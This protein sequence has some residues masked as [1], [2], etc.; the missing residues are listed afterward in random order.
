MFSLKGKVAVITGGASGIGKATA[1]R[2][3]KAG[4]KVV[5]ADIQDAGDVAKEAGGIYVRTDVTKEGEVKALME[6][7]VSECGKLDI[8]C[9]N[10]GVDFGAPIEE[11]KEEDFDRIMN[12]NAKS[13]LWGVKHA[14]PRMSDGG[15][16]INTS[17]L[18]GLIGFPEYTAYCSSKFAIVGISKTAALELA[19][20]RIRVNC[21]CPGS[22]D[23]PMMQ[24]ESAQAELALVP[25]LYPLGRMSTAEEIAALFHYLA[26]DESAIMTG[27]AIPIDGGY[28]AGFGL[29]LIEPLLGSE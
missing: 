24:V 18:A 19:P 15:S 20:R 29:Q 27:L 9:N 22:V 17:S 12:I 7:A 13:V 21:V 11:M 3:S 8:V 2:F 26:S 14:A 5:L 23:T 4:A 28:S 25:Y 1:L 10:V 6:K 16:I